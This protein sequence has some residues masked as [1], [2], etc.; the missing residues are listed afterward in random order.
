MAQTFNIRS[1]QVEASSV[2]LN[3]TSSSIEV[4]KDAILSDEENADVLKDPVQSESDSLWKWADV[5]VP[6]NETVTT[7]R[8]IYKTLFFDKHQESKVNPM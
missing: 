2:H 8:L 3:W 6:L 1:S 5:T 4:R 7:L